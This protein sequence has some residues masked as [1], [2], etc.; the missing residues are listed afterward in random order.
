MNNIHT[1]RNFLS[2]NVSIIYYSSNEKIIQG[3]RSSY[4][5]R[6]IIFH[7]DNPQYNKENLAIYLKSEILSKQGGARS[8]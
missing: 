3:I 6:A 4:P 1:F 8:N 2:L 5:S 7:S